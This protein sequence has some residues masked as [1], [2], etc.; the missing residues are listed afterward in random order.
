MKKKT[1]IPKPKPKATSR[2][3][4]IDGIALHYELGYTDVRLYESKNA[5]LQAHPCA[6]GKSECGVAKV[7]VVFVE[8]AKKP[9]SH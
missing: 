6:Q 9:Y 4:Y 1:K 7:E 5:V 2:T 3:A 8:W